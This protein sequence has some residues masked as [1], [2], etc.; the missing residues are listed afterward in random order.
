MTHVGLENM[1]W[2][3]AGCELPSYNS[4]AVPT[5]RELAVTR[6]M[7]AEWSR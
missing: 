5:S 4:V 3:F 2:K 1:L 7:D 6:I